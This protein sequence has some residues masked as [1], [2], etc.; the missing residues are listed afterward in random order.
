MEESLIIYHGSEQVVSKPML[1]KCKDK[2]DYGKGF[3]CTRDIELAREWACMHNN[4]GYVNEYVL[5]TRNLSVLDLSS[6]RYHML[7]WIAILLENR[8]FPTPNPLTAEAKKYVLK[9][10][11]PDYKKYDVIIGHRA[12]DSYFAYAADFISSQ[13]TVEQ[14]GKA[15]TLGNLGVQVFIQSQKAFNNLN[16]VGKKDV[17]RL[18][19]FTKFSMRDKDAREKYQKEVLHE[20]ASEGLFVLD[21]LR[22]EIKNEDERLRI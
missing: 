18:I 7:N 22:G 8:I 17:D 10:F 1:E 6:E 11:L 5:D 13:L 16:F 19:Y 20:K 2:R 9:E 21:I 4:D 3:Y 15:M 12:D 14:L